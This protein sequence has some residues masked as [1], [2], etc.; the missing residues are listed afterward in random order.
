[1]TSAICGSSPHTR[2]THRLD[3]RG[4][5]RARFI[6]AYAGNTRSGAASPSARTVHP[7]IRGERMVTIAVRSGSVGSSPHTRGTQPLLRGGRPC[8]RVIPVYAGNAQATT[9]GPYLPDGSSPHARG[10]HR[11]GDDPIRP[12]RFIP[13]YAGNAASRCSMRARI[14]V[15]P[16]MRGERSKKPRTFWRHFGSSPHTRGTRTQHRPADAGRRFIPA[17]AGNARAGHQPMRG[18]TVHPRIRGERQPLSRQY[19]SAAGSSP[20][21]RGTQHA[22]ARSAS[23]VRF[24]P[25]YAGN[26]VLHVPRHPCTAVH[27]RIRGE[28]TMGNPA[29]ALSIGSSPHT[30]GT[31]DR[32][33]VPRAAGRFIPAYAGN[34]LI[35]AAYPRETSV[36]PRI[37]GERSSFLH[38]RM[39]GFGSSPHTR[40]TRSRPPGRF[41]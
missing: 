8:A 4:L 20:H 2:G 23:H 19:S 34:A 27:P 28:R 21:T 39:S 15:H 18:L 37:R 24:I 36:H 40:G 38:A 31:L 22:A 1:M 6:P 3:V 30:R 5:V 13:A 32:A 26:A 11:G 35:T 7:R 41:S 33:T 16:R 29:P 17:Y 14:S 25:A 9:T 10:T 12:V